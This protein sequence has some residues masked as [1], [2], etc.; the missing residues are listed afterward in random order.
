M[1]PSECKAIQGNV[2]YKSPSKTHT[3]KLHWEDLVIYT[4]TEEPII[5]TLLSQEK[6]CPYFKVTVIFLNFYRLPEGHTF[7]KFKTLQY[8]NL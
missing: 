3:G 4:I 6:Q 5:Q 1:Y 2:N 8:I 7:Y